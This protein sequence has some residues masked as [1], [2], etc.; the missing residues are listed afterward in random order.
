MKAQ[1][2]WQAAAIPL[3]HV[4]VSLV[5]LLNFR[6]DGC[7]VSV[8]IVMS[9]GGLVAMAA[10]YTAWRVATRI[11]GGSLGDQPP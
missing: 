1:R 3:I 5:S 4:G 11:H 6:Q 8:P 9:T 2:Y 10:A 7:Y